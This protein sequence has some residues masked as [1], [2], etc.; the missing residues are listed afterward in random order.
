[1]ATV[2]EW[3]EGS[4]AASGGSTQ[5]SVGSVDTDTGF[6][7]ATI[8]TS[9]DGQGV[10]VYWDC[11]STPDSGVRYYMGLP[12]RLHPT[13]P[14]DIF[15]TSVSGVQQVQHAF[16][17]QTERGGLRIKRSGNVIA[18]TSTAGLFN[19][20]QIIRVETLSSASAGTVRVGLFRLGEDEP[21]YD[22]GLIADDGQSAITRVS[23]GHHGNTPA[24]PV[25]WAA[26]RVKM[27]DSADSWVGRDPSDVRAAVPATIVGTT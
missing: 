23:I 6:V 11:P 18:Q 21:F 15:R 22:T 27:V 24:M 14:A 26:S 5:G 19:P 10:R 25:T 13:A 8:P 16:P 7:W 9:A 20:G 12:R 3:A 2:F 1:M 17:P 4:V